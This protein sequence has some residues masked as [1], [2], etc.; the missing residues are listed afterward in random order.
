MPELERCA[1][2][3]MGTATLTSNARLVRGVAARSLALAVVALRQPRRVQRRNELDE[4]RGIMLRRWTWRY[5][6]RRD[7]FHHRPKQT[8]AEHQPQRHGR[9]SV[10]G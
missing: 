6:S 9:P 7:E 5:S 10:L 4:V 3:A 2:F 1:G 8:C